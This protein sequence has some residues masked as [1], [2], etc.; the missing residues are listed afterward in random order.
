MFIEN[1]NAVCNN[2][3]FIYTKMVDVS[4]LHP[5]MAML[6]KIAAEKAKIRT[7]SALARE[8]NVSPQTVKNWSARGIS[9][10]G[11]MAAQAKFGCD[12]NE[13][14]GQSDFFFT[15]DRDQVAAKVIA[16][17]PTS[18]ELRNKTQDPYIVE[19][20]DIFERLLP[21]DRKGAL[22]TLKVYVQNLGPPRDGQTLFLAG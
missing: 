11:A 19:A 10:E 1:A 20:I 13:L 18:A 6:M 7:P 8:L 3:M 9:K 21:S 17:E 5:S 14:R 16:L 22:A 2:A 12:A 4:K 15:V